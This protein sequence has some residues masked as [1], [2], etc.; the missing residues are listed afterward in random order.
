LV[1]FYGSEVTMTDLN[2][3]CDHLT[4]SELAHQLKKKASTIEKW[5]RDR[6]GPPFTYNG[7]TPLYPIAGVREWLVSREIKPVRTARVT[8]HFRQAR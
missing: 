8:R 2:L 3:L 5:R 7:K 6:T 1:T 4:E